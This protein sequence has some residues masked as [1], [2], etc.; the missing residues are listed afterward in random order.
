MEENYLK[1]KVFSS[2]IWRFAE[3]FGAQIVSFVV[4][5]ILAR[6][7]E[8]SEYG[9]IALVLVFTNILQ[10]FIDGGLGNALIQKKDADEVDFS[11]VFF[12][13]L[14]MCFG[15]Y[16]LMFFGAPLIAQFYNN[17]SLVSVIRVLSLALVIS[18]FKNIQKAY[19]TKKMQFKTLFFATLGGTI[20]SAVLGI[21]M[22]YCGY[23]IWA[24]VAQILF[25]DA[26]DAIIIWFTVDWRPKLLFSFERMKGLFSYGGKLLLSSLVDTLYNNL[27][28]LLVG[29]LYTSADLAYYNK[30]KQFPQLIISNI[31]SSIDTVLLPAMSVVQ[32]EKKRVKAMTQRAISVN[33]YI[34]WPMMIGLAVVAKPLVSII[35]TDKWL[36]CVPYM[37]VFCL[38][39]VF[40]PIHTANLNAMKAL[41][42]S[43]LFLG[44]SIIKKIIGVL[45]LAVAVQF[46][47]FAMALAGLISSIIETFINAYPNR[48]LLGYTYWE[49]MKDVVPSALLA[50]GMGVVRYLLKF[51]M[52][53]NLITLIVQVVVGGIIYILGSMVFK[54][55]NLGYL[56]SI[57]KKIRKK[58]NENE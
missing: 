6:L 8:P 33:S 13:N 1:E 46:G 20:G 58:E 50:I 49:Q 21:I 42:R 39:L 24:L 14:V 51:F 23:G 47:V 40:Y 38:T 25:N 57:V 7:I 4:S 26:V 2:F 54:F 27:T 30:G 55:D 53:N 10:V 3:K 44:L 29:T 43:D 48:K 41:G 16:V 9:T 52:F 11:T 32:D 22:A 36:A 34:I 56:W 12:Y 15:L 17:D 45:I 28:Q 18:G 35:L 5:V 37:R 31:N 19:I